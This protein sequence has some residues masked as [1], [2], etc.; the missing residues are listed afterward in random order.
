MIAVFSNAGYAETFERQ[1]ETY[2]NPAYKDA[3][4][5]IEEASMAKPEAVA[6][7]S[8]KSQL[9][10]L[11]HDAMVNRR[12]SI[13][14][15]YTGYTSNI[16]AD[17]RSVFDSAVN[18]DD[19]LAFSWKS[20]RY[21]CS[22]YSGN[23]SIYYNMSYLT[24]KSQEDYVDTKVDQILSS[25]IDDDMSSF[26]KELKIH[27]YIVK[28]V[29]YDVNLVEYSAYAALAYGKTVCQGYS[30]LAYKM[31]EE[32]GLD[33]RIVRSYDFMNHA[34][35]L[36]N[37]DGYWYHVDV[38]WDDPVPD[39]KGRTT[40]NY[41][42]L[43]DYGM[44]RDHYW[45]KYDYPLCTSAKYGFVKD[46]TYP[47]FMDEWLYYCSRSDGKL[48]SIG[49]D[50]GGRKL[51]YSGRAMSLC[52]HGD[53]LYYID[54]SNGGCIYKIRP[55]GSYAQKVSNV[56]ST[57]L[58]ING[59]TLTYRD[60]YTG[61]T[62]RIELGP[63][64]PER[65]E[66]F[67]SSMAMEKGKG[68]SIGWTT[69]PEDIPARLEWSS[70]DPGVVAVDSNGKM[71]ALSAGICTITA[72]VEE[73]EISDSCQISVQDPMENA[74]VR[75]FGYKTTSDTEKTWS[76]RFNK[77]IVQEYGLLSRVRV[78]KGGVDI[79]AAVGFGGDGSTIE[80]IPPA[81]GY[82]KGKSYR[83]YIDSGFKSL[84]GKSMTKPVVFYFMIE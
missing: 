56:Y 78:T 35:N 71:T 22:G 59:D 62:Y 55:D 32:A 9:E 30:L 16:M 2:V 67:N 4:P 64:V 26:E 10:S 31:F 28:N 23:Y 80:I 25:I 69:Y 81:T 46:V 45:N 8:S 36:V 37:I 66:L 20:V 3:V 72:R 54:M 44:A 43:T 57:D 18:R 70:S 1:E 15:V 74:A 82:E 50:G 39:V 68:A 29:E 60:G 14:A 58:Q 6:Y 40:Y 7:V 17:M 38:T 21:G 63:A 33:A 47:V 19:Y 79:G 65:I 42:N 13:N 34:W 48:Y 84:D 11:L 83:A 24:T 27:D 76:V 51:L 5:D 49:T 73:S 75:V 12:A 53:W 52:S 41:L 77:G 61:V